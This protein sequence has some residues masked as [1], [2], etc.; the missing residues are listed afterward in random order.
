MPIETPTWALPAL[1]GL[2][3]LLV[4]LWLARLGVRRRTAKSRRVGDRGERR[5]LELLERHGYRVVETQHTMRGYIEVDGEALSYSVRADAIVERDGE[6]FIA[7][8]KGGAQSASPSNRSTRRQLLEYAYLY[9]CDTVL[10]VDANAGD[11]LQV[12]FAGIA[13]DGMQLRASA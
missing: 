12:A 8:F 9:G 6:R 4:G 5:A 2:L 1:I 3:G 7:E 13:G 11:V 10:L